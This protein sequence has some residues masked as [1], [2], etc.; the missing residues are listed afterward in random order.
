MVESGTKYPHRISCPRSQR[1][2]PCPAT[3]QTANVQNVR[4]SRLF[5]S[6]AK[7]VSSHVFSGK[8]PFP[9]RNLLFSN[10]VNQSKTS[11]IEAFFSSSTTSMQRARQTSSIMSTTLRKLEAAPRVWV[12]RARQR[13]A[14]RPCSRTTKSSMTKE[15]GL[16]FKSVYTKS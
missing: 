9:N 10:T 6:R 1:G 13:L 16:I 4:L 8:T 12:K 11:I 3:F 2:R 15:T 14:R 5:S 7:R